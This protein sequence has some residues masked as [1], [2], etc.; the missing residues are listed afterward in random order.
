[1]TN[2][3][4]AGPTR[5]GTPVKRLS[6]LR[7]LVWL[8]P[9]R[10]AR[11]LGWIA[12]VALGLI[13]LVVVLVL[14]LLNRAGRPESRLAAMLSDRLTA[15]ASIGHVTMDAL[16]CREIEHLTINTP[17]L[18]APRGQYFPPSASATGRLEVENGTLAVTLDSFA[19]P[20]SLRIQKLLESA[21]AGSDLRAISL[22]TFAVDLDLAG[23]RVRANRVFADVSLAEGGDSIHGVLRG[24]TAEG[25][26]KAEF[27]LRDESR[28]LKVAGKPLAWMRALLAPTLGDAMA[29]ALAPGEGELTVSSALA[30]GVPGDTWRLR[31]KAALDL[32]RLPK[33]LGLDGITASLDLDLDAFGPL[34]GAA[35]VTAALTAPK[36]GSLSPTALR[37][38]RTLLN[39]PAAD[40][41]KDVAFAPFKVD[42][43]ITRDQ[44]LFSPER[45]ALCTP[46][47]RTLLTFPS[48]SIP[49]RD[50]FRRLD[51]IKRQWE[52]AHAG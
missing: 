16:G 48:G 31:A 42:V 37:N 36:G 23:E 7:S 10:I 19:K 20:P 5:K 52:A 15:D 29:Q 26:L 44:V 9:E 46:D 12:A 40:E 28:T 45:S 27:D 30:T 2:A 25:S 35:N 14:V 22:A 17:S 24:H 34:D 43:I 11:R 32:A 3:P 49:L 50:L 41:S 33:E 1:M 47:G 13:P 51:E 4:D 39:V 21:R 8:V 18:S 6:R 38:L